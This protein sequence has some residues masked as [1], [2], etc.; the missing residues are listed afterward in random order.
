MKSIYHGMN[1]AQLNDAYNLSETVPDFAE[2]LNNFSLRSQKSRKQHECELD[3]SYGPL[4]RNTF[5]YFP[6]LNVKAPTIIFIHGG[7]WQSTSKDIYSFIVDGLVPNYNVILTEYTLAPEA[8]LTQIFYEIDLMLN[9]L[10]SNMNKYKLTFGKICL[11]GHSAGAHLAALH[12]THPLISHAMWLS[13]IADL[14][15]ISL[16]KLNEKLQLTNTEIQLLSPVNNITLSIP[17]AVHVGSI[18]KSEMLSHSDRY[19]Q[20]LHK[21]GNATYYSR[22]DKLDHF[23]LLNEFSKK[24]GLLVK[25]LDTLFKL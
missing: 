24:E 14:K 20:L 12:R 6:S 8:S 3:I 4:P 16:C 22:L 15:P 10:K 18:E 23:N 1:Q 9:Y 19:A 7:F 5:D 21:K 11:S 17:T 25:S 2:L 13:G